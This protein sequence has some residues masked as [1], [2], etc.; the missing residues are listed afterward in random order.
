MSFTELAPPPP[1][2]HL[3]LHQHALE[4]I[5]GLLSF[6]ELRTALLVSHRWLS[7]VYSMRGLSEGKRLRCLPACLSASSVPSSPRLLR[8]VTSLDPSWTVELGPMQLQRVCRSMPFLRTLHFSPL[9]DVDWSEAQRLELP[10]TLLEVGLRCDEGDLKCGADVTALLSLLSSHQPPQTLRVW[11]DDSPDAT[12]RLSFAPLQALPN[13]ERLEV[14]CLAEG[15]ALSADQIQQLRALTQLQCLNI[16]NGS[17]EQLLRLLEPPSNSQF[18]WRALPTKSDVTDAV[19]ALLPALPRL[20]TLTCYVIPPTLSSLTFLAQ[21]PA[22]TSFNLISDCE[23]DGETERMD[24]LLVALTAPLPRIISFRLNN[25]YLSTQQLSTLLALM[26]HLHSLALTWMSDVSSLAFLAPV[27]ST[28]RSLI[29]AGCKHAELTPGALLDG[30]AGLQLTNLRITRS[31][32]APLDAQQTAALTPPSTLL[33]TL[34]QFE[35]AR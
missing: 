29:L 4:S 6:D 11:L 19:A 5:F 31:L 14:A 32:S 1:P 15:I 20:R 23:E 7:A 13:L 33:P 26:P 27:C 25:S 12:S 10:S 28:L 34:E 16:E 35:Y 3:R 9:P 8:H 18:Q 24:A 2:P 21:M 30:I 22:L 17:E